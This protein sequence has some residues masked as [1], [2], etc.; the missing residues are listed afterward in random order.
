MLV[1]GA[2]RHQLDRARHHAT[3]RCR[4][5]R[6]TGAFV[7]ALAGRLRSVDTLGL[8]LA[9]HGDAGWPSVSYRLAS[10][11]RPTQRRRV[12]MC[13]LSPAVLRRCTM[14]RRSRRKRVWRDRA[15]A[16][17]GSPIR[18][19]PSQNAIGGSAFHTGRRV[20]YRRR[21]PRAGRCT[22][23]SMPR[24]WVLVQPCQRCRRAAK[25]RSAQLNAS[26]P[27]AQADRRH[28]SSAAGTSLSR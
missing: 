15:R 8:T 7:L 25:P 27:R 26:V 5:P 3:L 28:R 23:H 22:E 2:R 4:D 19:G 20:H 9:I 11:L 6:V 24:M 10:D 17:I 13:S 12:R 14:S 16:T 18:V 21:T 1:V